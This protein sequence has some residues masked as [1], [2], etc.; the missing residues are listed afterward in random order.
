MKLHFAASVLFSLA[1]L[2]V[3]GCTQAI[4]PAA[5]ANASSDKLANC[6]YVNAV[7]EQNPYNCYPLS[8]LTQREKCLRDSSDS[9]AQNIVENM[10]SRE[11]DSIFA[12]AE[13]GAPQLPPVL[14]ELP[15]PPLGNVSL[16]IQPPANTSINL[17]PGISGQDAQS[18]TQAVQTND[19]TPCVSITDPSTRASCITQVALRVKKPSICDVLTEQ[20]DIDICNLYAKAG[21]QAK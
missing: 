16:P 15:S 2:A 9:N 8:N 3:F 10:N 7:L 18:F 14:P 11:R 17:P 12:V 6:I 1:L 20:D 4:A 21:E 13:P 5:C 19:M